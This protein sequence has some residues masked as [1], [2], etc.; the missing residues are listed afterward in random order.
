MLVHHISVAELADEFE[1]EPRDRFGSSR[2]RILAG[3]THVHQQQQGTRGERINMALFNYSHNYSRSNILTRQR[4]TVISLLKDTLSVT[5]YGATHV[6]KSHAC[7]RCV[8]LL[9]KAMRPTPRRWKRV[10]AAL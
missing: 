5:M 10:H 1:S 6:V 3:G 4:L 7:R 8:Y 2:R 9:Q